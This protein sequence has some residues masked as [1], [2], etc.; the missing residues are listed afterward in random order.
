MIIG[1]SS[2]FWIF[3]RRMNAP[4]QPSFR[5]PLETPSGPSGIPLGPRSWR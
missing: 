5:Y 3:R 1:F 2:F 4:R